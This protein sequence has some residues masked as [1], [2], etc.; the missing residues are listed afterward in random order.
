MTDSKAANTTQNSVP[1][2]K[3]KRAITLPL[4]KPQIDTPIYVKIVAAMSIGKVIGDKDA[5]ILCNVVNLE[6]GEEA[7]LIIPSVLQGIFHDDFGAPLYGTKEKGGKTVEL[8][9]RAKEAT[10][11]SYV[12][13]GFMITKHAKASG[14]QYNPYSV[15]ELELN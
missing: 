5:A 13:L 14:K 7:Q 6:T 1:T 15:S 12:N 4:V 10:P 2:F 8:E 11:D 9:G 3:V